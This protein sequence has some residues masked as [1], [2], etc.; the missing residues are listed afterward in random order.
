MGNLCER[1]TRTGLWTTRD[2]PSLLGYRHLSQGRVS[3]NI[4]LFKVPI[5]LFITFLGIERPVPTGPPMIPIT[6]EQPAVPISPF[7]TVQPPPI[8]LPESTT[9]P[10]LPLPTGPPPVIILP[11]PTE[12]PPVITLPPLTLP[13]IIGTGCSSYYPVPSQQIITGMFDW[14]NNNCRRGYCPSNYCICIP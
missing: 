3:L 10:S 11:V 2:V 6:T 5:Y 12:Q 1:N 8:I 7:P 9:Q 4:Y 14:C 13:P